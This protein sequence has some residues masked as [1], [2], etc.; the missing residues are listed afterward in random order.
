MDQQVALRDLVEEA[1]R[2]GEARQGDW[3]PRLVVQVGAVDRR[4]LH[5]VGEI[6]H[7]ADRVHLIRG[8]VQALLELIEHRLRHLL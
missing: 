2:G 6:E 1:A 4:H 7:P 5:Q 8:D 3:Y